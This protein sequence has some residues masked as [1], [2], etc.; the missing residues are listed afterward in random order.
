MQHL[1]SEIPNPKRWLPGAPPDN[2]G[3]IFEFVA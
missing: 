1:L 3:D 2:A